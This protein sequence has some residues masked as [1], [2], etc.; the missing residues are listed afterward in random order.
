MCALFVVFLLVLFLVVDLEVSEFV[1]IL[2]G[3]DHAKPVP[4]VV[5]LEVLLGQVLQVP[6][7]EGCGRGEVDLV[8]LT[9]QSDLLAEVVG[10]A[11]NLMRSSK[12]FSKSWQ[13]MMPSSTGWVQ[14][15]TN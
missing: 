2:G 1:G 4:Q 10:L 8:L 6:L 15:M 13:F 11:G 14:S 9:H 7:G 5:L 12:Y 3:G